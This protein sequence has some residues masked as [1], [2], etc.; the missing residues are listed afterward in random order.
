MLLAFSF[1]AGIWLARKRAERI[2]T[3]I[4]YRVLS[5]RL[6]FRVTVRASRFPISVAGNLFHGP[7]HPTQIYSS[8]GAAFIVW[9][10]ERHRPFDGFSFCVFL[11]LYGVLRICSGF[12]MPNRWGKMK[13]G[14]TQICFRINFCEGYV[15]SSVLDQMMSCYVTRRSQPSFLL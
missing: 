5:E 14:G 3:D 1:L 4:A 10:I 15:C 6:L 2:G 11:A 7:I 12:M 13:N 8:V 9:L